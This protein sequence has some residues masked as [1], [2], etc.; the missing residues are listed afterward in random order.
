MRKDRVLLMNVSTGRA[1]NPVTKT[2][3]EGVGV[4]PNVRV[5][6][7]HA[8]E[9]ALELALAAVDSRRQSH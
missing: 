9:R 3:S 2:T 8:L 1:I 5:D 7:E 4:Q 6:E